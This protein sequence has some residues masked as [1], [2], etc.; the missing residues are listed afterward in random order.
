[1]ADKGFHDISG[2]GEAFGNKRLSSRQEKGIRRYYDK[3]DVARVIR[4]NYHG[5]KEIPTGT[6]H[7]IMKSA[8]LLEKKR[9]DND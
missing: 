2:I 4:L 9:G 6:C 7:A 3:T 5:S 8:G 1:M